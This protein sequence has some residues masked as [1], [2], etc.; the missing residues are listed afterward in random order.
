MADAWLFDVMGNTWEGIGS[1]DPPSP[2]VNA[3]VAYDPASEI[4]VL[5][6]GLGE[7]EPEPS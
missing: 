4:V 2:R 3:A 7:G 5:F 1:E 6:G